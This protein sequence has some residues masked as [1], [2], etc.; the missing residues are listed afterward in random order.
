MEWV[1]QIYDYTLNFCQGYQPL[2]KSFLV[3]T[4]LIII[5][6][7]RTTYSWILNNNWF[8]FWSFLM[9]CIVSY[10]CESDWLSNEEIQ[11]DI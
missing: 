3:A 5:E 2:Q 11:P 6:F 4:V 1:I 7:I 9:E 8:W 10:N